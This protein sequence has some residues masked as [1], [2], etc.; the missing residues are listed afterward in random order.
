MYDLFID[1]DANDEQIEFP[2]IYTNAK[3][4]VAH[5]ELS[6]NS[7]DLTPLYELII[8][9]FSGPEIEDDLHTQFLITNIDFD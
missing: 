3:D 5:K 1:L 9:T 6:D 8:D 4:G 2:I 7:K